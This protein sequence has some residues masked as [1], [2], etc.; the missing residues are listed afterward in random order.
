MKQSDQQ[1]RSKISNHRKLAYYVGMGMTGIGLILFLSVFVSA[2]SQM[3]STAF[4]GFESPPIMRGIIGFIMVFI[5]QIIANIAKK[6][7]AGSGVLLDPDKA[8]ED[9]APYTHMAGGM[10]KDVVAGYHEAEGKD[11]KEAPQ[12]MLRCRGCETLNPEDAKYCN[13]CGELL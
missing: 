13:Q 3:S 7:L 12:V 10:V 5:G 2:A 1:G 11:Q 8:R 6:G 4:G 9:L